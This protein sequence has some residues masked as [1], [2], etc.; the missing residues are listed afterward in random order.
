MANVNHD[1]F[2]DAPQDD[3]RELRLNRRD[4]LRGAAKAVA[5][6]SVAAQVLAATGA[7]GAF[8]SSF[9]RTAAA[10]ADKPGYGPLVVHTGEMSLPAGFH[11]VSFGVA[12]TPMSDGNTTPNYHD[13]TTVVSAGGSRVTVM[14]NQEGFDPGRALGKHKAYDRVAQGGVTTS[15]FDTA[16]G[17]LLGSSLVLNGTDNNCNGGRT[18]W[19]SWLSCEESTV[20]PSE[21][22]EKKHGYVFEVPLDATSPVDPVPIR[23][24]GRFEHEAC[25]IDPRTGIVYM[26]EDNGDP[27]DGFYRYLPHDT[28]RLHKGG[29][30][31]MLC[32]EGRSRYDTT[33]HQKVGRTLRCEWVTIR[34]PDP[35][36]AEAHPDAVYQQGRALGAARF[37][38]LEG[39]LWSRGHVYFVASESGDKG[40]GQIWRYTPVGHKHGRLTLLYESR[41]RSVLDQP[42]SLTVSPRGGVVVCEDGDGE[43]VA[44]GTNFIRVLTPKG[45]IETFA[46]NDTPLDLHK[47]EDGKKGA[48]GRSEWSGAAYSPDGRWLFVHIQYPGK[49]FAITGPW[50]KGWL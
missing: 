22:F 43:D 17:R 13:G 8:A 39:A 29:V 46:R 3:E 25:A 9:R 40:E 18:P 50:E 12:G 1:P 21:G 28:R 14:R 26:T 38:G 7:P 42:D 47:W 35:E 23:A 31:Q 48:I 16:S 20:G 19:G 45:T 10:A 44:G 33:K 34:D 24:M 49:T 32:V 41:S 6:A 11:A 4:A 27:G 5:G 15:L 30:L 37:E 2:D 36:H